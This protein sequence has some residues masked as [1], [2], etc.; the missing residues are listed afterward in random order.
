MAVA[1][2][3][4]PFPYPSNVVY[5]FPEGG[6]EVRGMA[7]F[8]YTNS[9]GKTYFLHSKTVVLRGGRQQTLYYFAGEAGKDALQALPDGY[10]VEETATG[11][12]VLKKK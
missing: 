5:F 10:K 12:P 7:P 8:A 3:P 6:K 1:G 11:L 4:S 9:K 2:G